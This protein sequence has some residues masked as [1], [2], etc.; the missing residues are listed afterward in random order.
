MFTEF[1]RWS[2]ITAVPADRSIRR[3]CLRDDA[4]GLDRQ[5]RRQGAVT[6]TRR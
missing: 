4:D 5:Q 3:P 6:T 1:E 2:W